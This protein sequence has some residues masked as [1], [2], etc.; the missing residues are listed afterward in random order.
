MPAEMK[1]KEDSSTRIIVET[2]SSSRKWS[3]YLLI[4]LL[5]VPILAGVLI[6]ARFQ[7]WMDW[8]IIP[9][10]ILIETVV[11][12]AVYSELVNVTVIVDMNSQRATRI[13]N[14]FFIRTKKIELDFNQINRVLIHCEEHGHHCRLL[15]DSIISKPLVI[16]FY[17]PLEEKQKASLLLSKKIGT[18]L[19]KP[20]VMK[21]TDL[22]NVISE[23]RI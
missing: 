11:V 13:E 18:L 1:L 7:S 16:D 19:K 17:L 8:V 20:A 23:N 5:P 9:L 21:V 12:L 10:A 2:D 15:L 6:I 14:F 4:L 3:E 22:G